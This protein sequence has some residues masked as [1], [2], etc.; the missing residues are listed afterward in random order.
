MNYLYPDDFTASP[1]PSLMSP[2]LRL[3]CDFCHV[4]RPPLSDPVYDRCEPTR[5]MPLLEKIQPCILL[6]Q[7]QDR[8][9]ECSLKQA[10]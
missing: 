8:T 4:I 3:L 5:V 6:I 7:L 1:F 2:S 10:K 9:D